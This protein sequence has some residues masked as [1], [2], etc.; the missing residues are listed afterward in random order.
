MNR[1]RQH[2]PDNGQYSVRSRQQ[3]GNLNLQGVVITV[4]HALQL[5]ESLNN[6][7]LLAIALARHIP[8]RTTAVN[9][10]RD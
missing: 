7:M 3:G 8:S 10:V 5:L 4:R 2:Y 6:A 1:S 9:F